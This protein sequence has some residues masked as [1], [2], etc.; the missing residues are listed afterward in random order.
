MVLQSIENFRICSTAVGMLA[1][2][3]IMCLIQHH[4]YCDEIDNILFILIGR[5]LIVMTTILFV[6]ITIG[7]HKFSEQGAIK[8]RM[9]AIE[10]MVGVAILD[11]GKTETFTLNKFLINMDLIEVFIKGVYKEHVIP[12]AARTARL[13]SFTEANSNYSKVMLYNPFRGC[14]KI[15]KGWNSF[16]NLEDKVGLHG[17][18]N[19]TCHIWVP[20]LLAML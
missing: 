10:E 19:D 17:V 2:I 14:I 1:K 4:K 11:S 16:H 8:K 20:C 9:T 12:L 5:I 13:A 18:A 7:S 15:W 6:S 3:L